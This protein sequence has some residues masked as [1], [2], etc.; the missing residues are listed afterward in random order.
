MEIIEKIFNVATMLL[1]VF[2][3]S[4]IIFLGGHDA[5]LKAVLVA[6][7][8]DYIT[9][10]VRA[11]RTNTRSSRVGFNGILRK[12][13]MLGVVVFAVALDDALVMGDDLINARRVIL[14]F[15]IGNEG[16]SIFENCEALGIPVPK[17]LIS[18]LKK[19]KK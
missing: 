19:L 18:T 14:L 10:F 3:S 2:L 4:I 8:I 13:V 9:G 6:M 11:V 16:L 7:A 17:L 1:G 5:L 12:G 15:Y